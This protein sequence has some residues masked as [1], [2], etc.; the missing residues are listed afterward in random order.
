[1]YNQNFARVELHKL[2]GQL[3]GL[4]ELMGVSMH[5]EEL[6]KIL[7]MEIEKTNTLIEVVSKHLNY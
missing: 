4:W 2:K 3:E 1:M 5:D 6:V 7:R